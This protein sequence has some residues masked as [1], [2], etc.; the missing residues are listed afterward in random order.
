MDLINMSLKLFCLLYAVKGGS[1]NTSAKYLSWATIAL[2][3]FSCTFGIDGNL[4]SYL[5]AKIGRFCTIFFLT[6]RRATVL[7]IFLAFSMPLSIK[8]SGYLLCNNTSFN[9]PSL[10][11]LF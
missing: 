6:L 4:G 5:T 3:C 7:G 10:M 9:S 11:S 2:Q 8:F 1:T